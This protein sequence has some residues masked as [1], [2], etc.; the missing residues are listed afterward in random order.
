MSELITPI[1]SDRI[2]KHMNEDHLDR[3]K[4]EGD[5]LIQTWVIRHLQIIM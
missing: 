5:E 3:L 1:I 2:C 4:F